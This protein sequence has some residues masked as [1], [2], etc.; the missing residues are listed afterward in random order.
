MYEIIDI[1]FDLQKKE[2]FD[3]IQK[4]IN[5]RKDEI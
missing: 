3:Y 2:A 1:V 5:Y 4:R